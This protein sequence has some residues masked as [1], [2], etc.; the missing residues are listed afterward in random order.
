MGSMKAQNTAKDE[1]GFQINLFPTDQEEEE[2][3]AWVALFILIYALH[4]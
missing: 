2:E 3:E 1:T 4:N